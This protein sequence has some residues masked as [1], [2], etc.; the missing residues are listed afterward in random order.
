V[1]VKET[2]NVGWP[3]AAAA[4]LFPLGVV[5]LTVLLLLGPDEAPGFLINPPGS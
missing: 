1:A 5:L 3:R 4:T 2:L